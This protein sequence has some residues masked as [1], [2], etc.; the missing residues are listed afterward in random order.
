MPGRAAQIVVRIV[1][2][3]SGL[4]SCMAT[5]PY[6]ILRGVGLPYQSEWIIFVILFPLAGMISLLAAVFPASWTARIWRLHDSRLQ[7]KSSLFSLPFKMFGAV[8]AVAYVLTITL[9]FTPH[10]WNLDSYLWTFLLCPVY[11]IR[12]DFDPA[13]AFIFGVLGPIDAFAYGAIGTALG[14]LFMACSPKGQHG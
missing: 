9:Y 10:E 1:F 8:A 4:V 5:V 11:L 7:D 6:A 3:L 13:R 14:F 12:A 2:L